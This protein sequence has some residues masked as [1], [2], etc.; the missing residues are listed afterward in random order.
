MADQWEILKKLIGNGAKEESLFFALESAKEMVK[1]YC[2][3]KTIPDGLTFTVV[4]M[5]ADIYKNETVLQ[6]G[7]DKNCAENGVVSS[8][9]EGDTTIEFSYDS[10][11]Q[12]QEFFYSGL[13]KNYRSQLNRYRKVIRK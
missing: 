5:A 13:L 4:R 1:N 12:E 8:I 10:S 3:I 7:T 2:H 6:A 11:K 9:Q